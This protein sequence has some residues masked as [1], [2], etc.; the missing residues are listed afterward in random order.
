MKVSD[1]APGF[2]EDLRGA[3]VEETPRAIAANANGQKQDRDA[4]LTRD[5]TTETPPRDQPGFVDTCGFSLAPV[6]KPHDNQP[7]YLRLL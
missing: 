3:G 1:F 4:P 5:L 6:N 7:P 2:T